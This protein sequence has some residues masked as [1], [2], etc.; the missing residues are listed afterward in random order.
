MNGAVAIVTGGASGIGSALGAELAARGVEVILA[1]RQVEM[2]EAVAESIREHGNKASA[3]AL[4]VRDAEQFDAIV[5]EIAVRHKR[6]DYLFNNAGI[7]IGGRADRFTNAD[8]DEVIDVNIRGVAHGIRA[9]YPLMIRQRHGHIVNTA[10]LAGL[11]PVPLMISY[12]AAK[13]AVV[14]MSKALRLE[15]AEHGI[16]VTALC[17]GLIR[18]PIL[19]GGRYGRIRPELGA[20]TYLKLVEYLRPSDPAR[21]ARRVVDALGRNPAVIIEPPWWRLIWFLDRALPGASARIT[22]RFLTSWFHKY[23]S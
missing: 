7:V 4:D 1:D 6:L 23:P 22:R 16:R 21:F 13:Y 3:I 2:A 11:C 5:R 17:P 9:A 12:V 8:W 19:N 20:E 14:G 15:A 10:S 18:T